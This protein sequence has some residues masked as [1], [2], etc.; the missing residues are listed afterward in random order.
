MLEAIKVHQNH[1]DVDASGA[2]SN[3]YCCDCTLDYWGNV[4]A[5]ARCI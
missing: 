2:A 4:V 1:P 5:F 3:V